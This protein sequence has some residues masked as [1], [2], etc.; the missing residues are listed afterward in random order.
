MFSGSKELSQRNE[1]T[2]REID[3]LS[4]NVIAEFGNGRQPVRK[5][6]FTICTELKCDVKDMM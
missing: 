3:Q 1:M 4:I 5:N 2:Q 6:M